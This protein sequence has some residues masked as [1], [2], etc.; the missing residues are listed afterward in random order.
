MPQKCVEGQISAP[1]PTGELTVPADLYMLD[2]R[3]SLRVSERLME[4][5]LEK[6]GKQK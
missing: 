4:R 1:D 3:G 5:G 2:L 6:V